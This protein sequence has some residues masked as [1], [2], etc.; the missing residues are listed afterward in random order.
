MRAETICISE[1]NLM[2]VIAGQLYDQAPNRQPRNADELCGKLRRISET[3]RC[4]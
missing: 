3:I 2:F 1:V 4:A